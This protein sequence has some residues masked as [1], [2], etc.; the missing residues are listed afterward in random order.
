MIE[1]LSY[2]SR[3]RD[4]GRDALFRRA[5]F[6]REVRRIVREAERHTRRFAGAQREQEMPRLKVGGADRVGEREARR[7]RETNV[8]AR[9]IRR[10]DV[11]LGTLAKSDAAH[12]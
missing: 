12:A 5:S 1:P 11:L 8:D 7:G 9:E 4:E 2:P 3:R 10:R 6:G